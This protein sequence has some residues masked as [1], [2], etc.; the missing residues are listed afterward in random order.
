MKD[1]RVGTFGVVGLISILGLKFLALT[2]L[3]KD[4]VG[5]ALML[6]LILSR[7]TMVQL[8]YRAPYARREGGLGLPFKENL[9]KREMVIA[10][11]TSLAL[12]VLIL[13]LWGAVLW[14]A[15]GIFTL[16]FEAFFEKKIGGITGDILGAANETNEVLALILICGML[17]LGLKF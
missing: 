8:A 15:L 4:A 9:K 10:A 16:L 5:K 7:G 14:A 13:R 11:I 17:Q 6:A 12:S 2:S 1:H 3:P